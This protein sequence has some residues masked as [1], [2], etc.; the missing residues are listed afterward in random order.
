MN[1]NNSYGNG[2]G[3]YRS[4]GNQNNRGGQGSYNNNRGG[5]QRAT[6]PSQTAEIIKTITAGGQLA[7]VL[8]VEKYALPSGWADTIANEINVE[9]NN[10]QLRKLFTEIKQIA[11][12]LETKVTTFEEETRN[13]WLLMPNIAYAKNR[14]VIKPEFYNLMAACIKPEKIKTLADYLAFAQFMEALV[15]YFPKK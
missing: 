5:Q 7:G 10:T 11:M 12:R 4:N 15:A 6:Q 9:L 3:N 13:I 8:T 14:G 1:Y 2:G